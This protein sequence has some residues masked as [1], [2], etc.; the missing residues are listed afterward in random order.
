LDWIEGKK[1]DGERERLDAAAVSFCFW[2][3][4]VAARVA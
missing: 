4:I 3:Y 2:I 1:I